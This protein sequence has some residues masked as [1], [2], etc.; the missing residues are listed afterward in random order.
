[1]PEFKKAAAAADIPPGT[2]KCV[3]IDGKEIAVFNVDGAF[4]AVANTCL[5]M[6]G[7]LGE[8]GLEGCV[9]KCP[10]HAWE[11]DVTTGKAV[12]QDGMNLARYEVK[13][14]GSDVWVGV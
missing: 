10:W 3:T 7:P 9:V 6:G 4:H 12:K 11:F 14:E 5:H 1:M 8:G 13:L 2:G